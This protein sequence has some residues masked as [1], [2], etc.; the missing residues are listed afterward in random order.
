MEMQMETMTKRERMTRDRAANVRFPLFLFLVFFFPFSSSWR[1]CFL[2][3]P[4]SC[5][6]RQ[7]APLCYDYDNAICLRSSLKTCDWA[8]WSCESKGSTALWTGLPDRL[9]HAWFNGSKNEQLIHRTPGSADS[10][11]TM[12]FYIHQ[13][14]LA[15]PAHP[16]LL[17]V[18]LF[19]SQN[20]YKKHYR[21]KKKLALSFRIK[22]RLRTVTAIRK[23][24]KKVNVRKADSRR[25]FYDPYASNGLGSQETL[26]RVSLCVFI[27]C[28]GNATHI[29]LHRQPQ[30]RA[31]TQLIPSSPFFYHSLACF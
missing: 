4:I 24:I 12:H 16:P 26:E 9:L 18:T 27:L 13:H 21:R 28:G 3:P 15:Y 7:L 23:I 14:V 30:L 29:Q 20:R 22:S 8:A 11:P 10:Q 25:V 19:Y 6:K 5:K 31:H 2:C 17:K 1:H